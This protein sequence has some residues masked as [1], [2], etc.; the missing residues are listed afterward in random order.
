MTKRIFR[1]ILAVS[2]A[3]LGASLVLIV[4]VL[5]GYFQDQVLAEL[6]SRTAYI[7]HGVE[8]EGAA[9][10]EGGFP[11][12]YRVTWVARDG[13]VLWDNREDPAHMENHRQR[14]EIQKAL[15]LGEGHAVRDS[16]T[17]SQKTIYTAIRLS[18]GTVLRVADRQVG[19]WLLVLQALQPVAFVILA[20][21]AL[22]LYLADRVARQL[23]APINAIDLNAPSD[24]EPYE[25]LAPLLG[26]IRSQNRQIQRQ[27]LDLK[28]RQEEF[29][30]ITE[31]MSEG[32]LVVDAQKRV[33]S[34]NSA[35]LELLRA[36]EPEEE[37]GSVFALNREAGF[38]RAV[39][40]ALSGYRCEQFLQKDGCCRQAI[41]SPVEQDGDVVG[42]VIVLLDVTEKEQRESL[43][44]EFTAN[45]SHELKTPLTA[46]LGTAEILQNG[47]VLEEDIPH[48]AG[49]IYRE[50]ARLIG[51]VNDIIKL[52][53]LD[54]GGDSGAWEAMELYALGE[55]VIRQL[56]PAAERRDVTVELRGS[57]AS[58]WGVPQIVEEILYNL[59][60]N[61]IAYNKTGGRVVITVEPEPSGS[62]VTVEDT[63]IGIPRQA[64]E[65]V[66]ERFYRM[67]QSHSGG[68][69]GLGLSIVKHGA[70]YLGAQITLHSEEGKGSRFTVRFPP[71]PP[72]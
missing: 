28:R 66:F 20:A 55:A 14:E 13:T 64:Q 61:A 26:K 53:R 67:D 35:A 51:L 56:A 23:V 57:R 42:A 49:N 22:A 4:G 45:V 3:V 36:T 72:T 15:A 24:G 12:D 58:V 60:D 63:G 71:L 46:I 30:A 47:L 48:F 11:D 39:E 31:N 40:Q 70:A 9:Y 7:A 69:T 27:M 6:K 21:A 50:T 2:L 52:S 16:N 44:R 62:T 29:S 10:F 41:A 25:E 65:R 68:G 1:S 19:V 59:C 43:R 17:L 18:D 54:E 38:R 5:H 8:R 34:R 32:F 37:G 33:L